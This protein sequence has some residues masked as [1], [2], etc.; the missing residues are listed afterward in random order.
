MYFTSVHVFFCVYLHISVLQ[1]TLRSFLIL[2]CSYPRNRFLNILH[3]TLY[4]HCSHLPHI[5]AFKLWL[6]WSEK[7]ERKTSRN[8][9]WLK[10]SVCVK[11]KLFVGENCHVTMS[12]WGTIED[13]VCWCKSFKIREEILLCQGVTFLGRCLPPSASHPTLTLSQNT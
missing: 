1:I 4:S 8:H 6:N 3:F 2:H 12:K 11:E 7:G 13:E 9:C 5:A 10:T